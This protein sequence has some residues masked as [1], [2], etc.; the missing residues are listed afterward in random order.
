MRT[1]FDWREHTGISIEKFYKTTLW[2]GQHMMVGLNC[3]E[4]GQTQNLH[5]HSGADKFYV[6]LEGAGVF[7][8]GEEERDAEMGAVIAAPAGIQ[9]GVKNAGSERLTLLVAISPPPNK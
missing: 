8:I 4:P 9:H 6:V 1:F 2:Q 7:T 3:L 5:A